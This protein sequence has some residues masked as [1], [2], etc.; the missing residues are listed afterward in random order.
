MYNLRI[1]EEYLFIYHNINFYDL[2]IL[3]FTEKRAKIGD[4]IKIASFGSLQKTHNL[5]LCFKYI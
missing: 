5:S 1:I 4:P 3:S 2:L